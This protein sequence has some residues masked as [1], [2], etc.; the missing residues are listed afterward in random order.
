MKK[1]L[2]LLVLIAGLTIPPK[3][4]NAQFAI[5]EVIKAGVKKVI[6]ALDL[7]IQRLQNETIWLQNAQK[8]IENALSKLK[9][10]E[11][12][13]WTEKQRTLYQ[14]YFQE[15]N[16]VKSLIAYYHR[17]RAISGRQV[18]LVKTYQ[19]TWQ[20]LRQD[21]HFSME[22]LEYM[23]K[24]Y[25]GILEESLRNIDQ[26]FLVVNSFQTQ[27]NDAERL[28]IIRKAAERMDHNYYD[29]KTFSQENI[30]LSLSRAKDQHDVD[31]VRKLYGLK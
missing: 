30:Q 23:S 18:Q 31:A 3:Q 25:G 16:K 22:E 29:L 26:V 24:V 4:V 12:S 17:I 5:A 21:A 28:E 13:G 7:R 11:I 8:T 2:I 1:F 9:L 27:M 15:L 14:D 20:L 10:E 19:H 6:K